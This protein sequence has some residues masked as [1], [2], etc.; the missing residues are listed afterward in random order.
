MAASSVPLPSSSP[1]LIGFCILRKL[2]PDVY[3][4][5]SRRILNAPA[6]KLVHWA[7]NNPG[8]AAYG[9]AN[10][11][12]NNGTLVNLE[13]D[14]SPDPQ[15]VRRVELV[16]EQLVNLNSASDNHKLDLYRYV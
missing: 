15:L 14:V 8:V 1:T 7:E 2:M 13:W 6:Q 9:M 12:E 11:L 3:V 16:L 5:I 10:V 4:E